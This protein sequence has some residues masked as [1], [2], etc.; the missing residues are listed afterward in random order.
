MGAQDPG[1]RFS[2]ALNLLFS[3]ERK[4]A[5]R[6]IA[7]VLMLAMVAEAQVQPRVNPASPAFGRLPQPSFRNSVAAN[8]W[9]K[10]DEKPAARGGR[11]SKGKRL[12]EIEE[13]TNPL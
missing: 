13:A 9:K 11:A 6:S 8:F 7:L 12:P 1:S 10:Q 5:M 2:L 4:R 3:K